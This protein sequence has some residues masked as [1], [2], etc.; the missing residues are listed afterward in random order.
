MFDGLTLILCIALVT[1][2]VAIA[3]GL[4]L[5]IIEIYRTFVTDR[6]E[7]RDMIAFFFGAL[8]LVGILVLTRELIFF[9]GRNYYGL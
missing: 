3:C 4:H 1:V 2:P 7:R 5:E 9:I 8:F 6:E